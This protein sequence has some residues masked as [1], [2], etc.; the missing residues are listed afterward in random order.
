MKFP[1]NKMAD[2]DFQGMKIRD[3]WSQNIQKLQVCASDNNWIRTQHIKIYRIMLKELSARMWTTKIV[4]W[5][6][7]WVREHGLYYELQ[8]FG[9]FWWFNCF[10]SRSNGLFSKQTTIAE[11]LNV[12]WEERTEFLQNYRSP[13]ILRSGRL[14]SSRGLLD[15]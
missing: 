10:E 7:F 12:K 1:W 3:V 2:F 6:T 11:I 15:L 8:V 14:V 4:F 13:K 9:H 5:T